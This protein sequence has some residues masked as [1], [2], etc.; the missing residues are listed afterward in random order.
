MNDIL[1]CKFILIVL[2][3]A[4]YTLLSASAEEVGS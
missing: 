2:L 1:S 3:Q 4:H